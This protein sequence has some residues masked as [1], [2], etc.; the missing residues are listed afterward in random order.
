[1]KKLVAALLII[2]L[3]VPGVLCFTSKCVAWTSQ[4]PND[5]ELIKGSVWGF[6][7]DSYTDLIMFLDEVF[8]DPNTNEVC[9]FAGNLDDSSITGFVK[10]GDFP[11]GYG[12]GFVC[13]LSNMNITPITDAQFYMFNTN[14]YAANGIYSY[15]SELSPSIKI[16]DLTGYKIMDLPVETDQNQ[17]VKIEF[18]TNKSSDDNGSN[19]SFVS[20][21]FISS[22]LSCK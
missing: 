19:D 4:D 9:L 3:F 1:M 2:A 16:S 22:L 17:P 18:S 14:G 12:R 15:F 6:T 7:H 8:T 11:T 5:L 20:G 13:M 21:C 10:F